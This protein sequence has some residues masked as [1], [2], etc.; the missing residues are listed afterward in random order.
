[1][2]RDEPAALEEAAGWRKT[3][4]TPPLTKLQLLS[5]RAELRC[6]FAQ[7]HFRE[8]LISLI[9]E[10]QTVLGALS[11]FPRRWHDGDP[12]FVSPHAQLDKG[13]RH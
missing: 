11:V 7:C 1:M 6:H 10:S 12:L 8:E 2:R 3:L 9:R 4:P 5:P 13:R